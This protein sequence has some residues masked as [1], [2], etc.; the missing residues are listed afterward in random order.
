MVNHV[1]AQENKGDPFS[2]EREVGT[3]VDKKSPGGS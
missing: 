2:R 1:Q 3:A